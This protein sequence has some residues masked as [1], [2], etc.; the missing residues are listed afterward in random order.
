M[1]I[2]GITRSLSIKMTK[3]K[4]PL[5]V[6]MEPMPIVE[7]LLG[8]VMHLLL[9]KDRSLSIKMTKEKPPLHVPMEPMPIVECL[10]G[11]VMHL[12][13]FKDV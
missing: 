2:H 4:P 10:L 5:H 12:L 11:Y 6:P 8:Y 3:E 13:L 9:F 7:C 1:D